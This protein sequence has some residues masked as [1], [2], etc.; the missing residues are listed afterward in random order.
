MNK[1]TP[2]ELHTFILFVMSVYCDP[3]YSHSSLLSATA[4]ALS[5]SEVEASRAFFRKHGFDDA[6]VTRELLIRC[7]VHAGWHHSQY[8]PRHTFQHMNEVIRQHSMGLVTDA[9][10]MSSVQLSPFQVQAVDTY[11][12]LPVDVQRKANLQD[13]DKWV[14]DKTNALTR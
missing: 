2:K 6:R 8:T 10:M 7:A 3:N 13:W 5:D 12:A 11:L 14:E 1:P 4:M 9:E